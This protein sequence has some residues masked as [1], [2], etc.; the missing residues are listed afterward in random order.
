MFSEVTCVILAAGRGRRMGQAKALLTWRNHL[1]LEHM[2][3]VQAS[4]GL[5]KFVVVL[6]PDLRERLAQSTF[7]LEPEHCDLWLDLPHTTADRVGTPTRPLQMEFV[8]SEPEAEQLVSLQH[9]WNHL[10][11]SSPSGLLVGPID[12]GP[13][14]ASVLQA[15]F[16]GFVP[17]AK[18]AW[19]PVN[20]GKRGHPVLLGGGALP[21]LDAGH[22]DGLRG[23]LQTH[24]E[25]VTEVSVASSAILRNL[26]TP[27]LY[28][29]FLHNT[30]G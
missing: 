19:I 2:I 27:S 26:N 10:R 12:Q 17:H 25:M 4:V 30:G 15:L 23:I 16:S 22:S 3:T 7:P 1:F 29:Q 14:P 20:N 8:V 28:K 21:L 6:P 9:A 5:R 11:Y 24:C 18:R 13:Y